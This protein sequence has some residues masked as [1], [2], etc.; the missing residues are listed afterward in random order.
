MDVSAAV[1]KIKLKWPYFPSFQIFIETLIF[2]LLFSNSEE[3]GDE[4]YSFEWAKKN[5]FKHFVHNQAENIFVI[6]VKSILKLNMV[7]NFVSV[8]V[9]FQQWVWRPAKVLWGH[10]K[11]YARHNQHQIRFLLDQLDKGFQLTKPN[12]LLTGI[13]TAL[14]AIS[15]A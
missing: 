14:Q 4:G 3:E 1:W 5:A 8:G 7:T 12:W 6:E 2:G 15:E 13:N 9:S 11:H 10:C